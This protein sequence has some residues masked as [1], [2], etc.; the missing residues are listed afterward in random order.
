MSEVPYLLLPYQQRWVADQSQVKVAEK[1]RRIG[2]TWA[3][4]ANCVVTAGTR[5]R[6]GGKDC[7]YIGYNK[8]QAQE[9]IRDCADWARKLS[10]AC[11]QIREEQ[12]EDI[13]MDESGKLI[14]DE[15]TSI[16]AYTIRFASGL[17]ITALS[18]RPSNLRGKQGHVVIDE[19][20]FH[21]SLGELLKAAMAL[22]M[23]GGSISVISTH[24][25]VDNEFNKIVEESKSGKRPFSVHRATFDDAI[26]EGLYQRICL[27]SGREWTQEAEDKFVA[28]T[29]AFYGDDA[30][31]ELDVVPRQGGGV[32]ISRPLIESRMVLDPA[33]HPVLSLKLPDGVGDQ[34]AFECECK[35]NAWLAEQVD[36]ITRLMMPSN[37]HF[38]GV[39]FGR[40][41][42]LTVIAV[43]QLTYDLVRR[44]PLILELENVPF[45][46]QEGI[47]WHI[48]QRI[49]RFAGARLDNGGLG[50]PIAEK[51]V[52]RWGLI[53][54]AIDLSDKWY[55]TYMPPFKSL[56]EDGQIELMRNANVLSDLGAIQRING[57]P[58][59]PKATTKS[60]VKGQKRHGDAAI[61]LVLLSAA[62]SGGVAAPAPS[63]MGLAFGGQRRGW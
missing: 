31:E 42:N 6:D 32:Y 54:E 3:E 16:L 47:L 44:V 30:D 27:M 33:A 13:S 40:V 35:V 7:W 4:A 49:P 1:S 59:V 17:R 21:D 23:W 5:K 28:D 45:S 25:G 15:K 14:E 41:A 18:S 46:L 51:A 20:A 12:I 19:A 62:M 52:Q 50:R 43:G 39:D 2:F 58:K 26:G 34:W 8:D 9:F 11:E 61:A 57:V 53:A 63:S 60:V 37:D 22:T 38:L 48:A 55:S 10:V 24:D 56:F 29:R 36:Q